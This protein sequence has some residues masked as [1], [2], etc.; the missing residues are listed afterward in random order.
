M[1][2]N[3][4]DRSGKKKSSLN[5]VYAKTGGQRARRIPLD[6][7]R[8]TDSI[9]RSRHL[10]LFVAILVSS[11]LLLLSVDLPKLAQGE[12]RSSS[13]VNWSTSHGEISRSHAAWKNQCEACHRSFTPIREGNVLA[14]IWPSKDHVNWEVNCQTCHKETLS[15]VQT[16]SI[17]EELSCSACHQEHR[18]LDAKLITSDNRLCLSCHVDLSRMPNP[19]KESDKAHGAGWEKIHRFALNKHPK[20]VSLASGK[21]PGNIKF[22]HQLHMAPGQGLGSNHNPATPMQLS[23]S[24]CHR[25]AQT[26]NAETIND[27][28]TEI[29]FQPIAYEEHCSKCHPMTDLRPLIEQKFAVSDAAASQKIKASL[30]EVPSIR[31]GVQLSE[32]KGEIRRA[33]SMISIYSDI[34]LDENRDLPMV[35]LP[36]QKQ[37]RQSAIASDEPVKKVE[38]EVNDIALE[39]NESPPLEALATLTKAS[40][41]ALAMAGGHCSKCHHYQTRQTTEDAFEGRLNFLDPSHRD[42][43]AGAMT[44]SD[45][46]VEIAPAN[47]KTVWLTKSQF[48]HRP[49][50]LVDCKACHE[51]AYLKNAQTSYSELLKAPHEEDLMIPRMDNCVQCHGRQT[52]EGSMLVSM[53]SAPQTAVSDACTLCHTYHNA[54]HSRPEVD[55]QQNRAFN[56]VEEFLKPGHKPKP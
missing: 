41:E 52:G 35:N 18:G 20:F 32:L 26:G 40:L 34:S 39:L 16:V 2:A 1:A 23:C 24:D 9:Q 47:I 53:L 38:P 46:L 31:H 15:H 44:T 11:G 13:L 29:D 55:Y 19:P 17:S 33:L 48:H 49:H 50:S 28:S 45:S 51:S 7:F 8:Q 56:N 12:V 43:L 21:D 37:P 25:P 30:G 27:P 42:L 10:F 22:N 36:G 3:S 4:A 14:L 54:D 5:R 6:Y